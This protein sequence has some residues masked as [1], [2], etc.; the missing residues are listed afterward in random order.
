MKLLLAFALCLSAFGQIQPVVDPYRFGAPDPCVTCVQNVA[1]YNATMTGGLQAVGTAAALAGVADSKVFTFSAWVKSNDTGSGVFLSIFGPAVE[2]FY[3][4]FDASLKVQVVGLN[5]AGSTILNITTDAALSVSTWHH[6]LVVIDLTDT[7]KRKIYVDGASVAITVA[8]YTNDTIDLVPTSPIFTAFN[9]GNTQ[10][11][12]LNGALAEMWFDDSY[13]DNVC[14]FYCSGKPSTLG[15]NGELP[16]GALP[17]GY[18]SLSGDALSWRTDSSGNGNNFGA[19]T[20]TPGST[21]PP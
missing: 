16:N 8:T 18:W 2:K 20:G 4:Q 14:Y 17:A 10:A 13:N 6:V 7:A 3:V 12:G 1:A 21:T 15:T 19:Y 5:A 11:K 9:E